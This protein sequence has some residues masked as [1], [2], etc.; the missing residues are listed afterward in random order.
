[1]KIDIDNIKNTSYTI[2]MTKIFCILILALAIAGCGRISKP[3]APKGSTYP[4]TYIVKE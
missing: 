4:E 1:M 2:P 3:Q